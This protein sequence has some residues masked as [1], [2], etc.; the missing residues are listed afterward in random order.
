MRN[1]GRLTQSTGKENTQNGNENSIASQTNSIME[2]CRKAV[3]DDRL[4]YLQWAIK[5]CNALHV[6]RQYQAS[7]AHMHQVENA[8]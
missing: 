6:S 7:I 1:S 4:E 2:H 8:V 5:H 3:L